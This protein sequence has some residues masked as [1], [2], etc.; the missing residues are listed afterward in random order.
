MKTVTLLVEHV[1][2]NLLGAACRINLFQ[3]AT[4]LVNLTKIKYN[5]SGAL[6]YN[7]DAVL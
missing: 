2:H 7:S 6:D 5:A 3:F 1:I 4:T